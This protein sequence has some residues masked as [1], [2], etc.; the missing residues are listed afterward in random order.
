MN[1]KFLNAVLFGAL[2]ASSAGTFTSCKDYDDDI[3]SLQEQID[4]SGST[5]G[6]LQTQLTTLKTAAEAAQAAADAA[7]TAAA[8][9]KTAAEAAKTVGDQAAADA[10]TAKALAEEAK[11]AASQAK[12]DA[13]AEAAKQVEALRVSLQSAIDQKVDLTVYEA[14]VKALGAQIEGIETGLSNL[15]NGAVKENTEAIKT[16][17][18]A[19]ETLIT[20]DKDLQTQLDALKLYAEGVKE[21]ADANAEDIKAAQEAIEA[22]QD[23]I[24][25]LWD[26]I[27]GEGGLKA[28]IGENKSAIEVLQKS[29]AQDIANLEDKITDELDAIKNDI[30]DVQSD[31]KTINTQIINI[32]ADL[33]SLHTLM[34]CRLTSIT[35]APDYIVDGVE[36]IK[37]NSLKYAA[38]AA[39]ENAVIPT[40]YKFSTAALATASYHFNPASFKLA[41]AD[42]SYIDRSATVINTRAA[43]SQWVEISGTPVANAAT[44]TVDFKLLRLNV[45]STQPAE[46]KVNMIALQAALKGDAVDQ[47]ETNVVVT[48]P[49]VSIYDDVLAAPD[50]RI[51]DKATLI[52]GADKAH[53][54]TTFDACKSEAVRYT[55]PYDKVFNLK[56]LVATC[57]G[58]GNH[59]EFPIEDYKLSYKFSVATSDYNVTSGST[60]TNQQKWIVCNDAKAGLY[61]AEG[62]NKEAIGRTPILKVELVDEAG[63]VVRRGFV[64]IEFGVTKQD[65]LVVG[66][67]ANDLVAKCAETA[68]SYTISEQFIRENVYR[69]I[70]NGKETSM[71]HEEF[72]NL[73]DA[74][75]AVAAVKKNN[76]S[77]SMSLPKIVDGDTS[78][79]TA[80]KKI[81]WSFTHTELGKIGAGGSQFV[82]TVTVKNKLTSSEYP[83]SITFKFT[84]N[85]KLPELTLAATENDLYW[86]KE[87][88]KYK[89]FNVNVNVPSSITSPAENCQF[90]RALPEAYSAYAV[91]GLPGCESARYKVIKTYSNGVATST[92]MNGVQIDGV[93]ITLD[94]SNA[95]V[96]AALNSANGLQAVVAHIYT[97]SNGDE[98][99]V[100]EFMV[101]FIR[102]VNL[103]MPSGISVT[104]AMTG[105]DVADFQ[106]NGL[107]TDWRNEAIVKDSWSWVDH[108][109]S[110]WKRVCAPEFEYVEGHE[111]MVT[112]AQLDVEYGTIKFT[113]TTTTTMYTGKATY[114]YYPLV[115]RSI[116]KTY[117]IEEEMLTKAEINTALEAKKVEGWPFGYISAELDG[118]IEYTEVSKPASTTIEYDYVK[119]INY[120]PAVYKWVE[121]NWTMVPHK[122]TA[123][124]AYEGTSYGQTSGC[125]EWTKKEWTRPE[126]NAGQ[127]WFFYG[128]FSD[129]TVNVNEA[130]TSLE[131][132]GNK[133]PDG[134]TLV[135]EGNTVK[136]VNVSSPVGYT[137]Q[138]FIPA[139]VNYGW[140]TTSSTLTITVNPKN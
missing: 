108:T 101:N 69:V 125:W 100:N 57:F 25:K 55:T 56:E 50:V 127:Y 63:N 64:K 30:K 47:N 31:I 110:Y 52:S 15:T 114:R 39:S 77:H 16:A 137:Y 94:K 11:A 13:I 104:D 86:T 96:K 91:T 1:K 6:D 80:T 129:V 117:T 126:W 18:D 51:S 84:V 20:A 134:A 98:V 44:G 105:G 38:M 121:G 88:G 8:E 123:M 36:A 72:W 61:Q 35:F 102:P 132:N 106:W 60:T 27:N 118:E 109:R 75:T 92:V 45:H 3:K 71:S 32:N 139:T 29:T 40:A 78:T 59:K 19:I 120:V 124:P 67:K 89:Y 48:S 136:Y 12:A 62:F 26:E 65:D 111:E 21:V 122:H 42:Y 9:A 82:A 131:Y 81:V 4:K 24:K 103:N 49:Y 17:Q 85:V 138:I 140:G 133:L 99:T 5:V 90:S 95:A 41:N 58:N 135:Q 2:I 37:F 83:A 14:A 10:A 74:T 130:T 66:D 76:L 73:Y 23:E 53:Y 116:T 87:D 28:L 113:T 115:G 79:G 43:A 46:D 34:T 68:A 128:P 54:A 22:A 107:L 7:K 97:L 33:A 70:T 112:P 119:S 93:N